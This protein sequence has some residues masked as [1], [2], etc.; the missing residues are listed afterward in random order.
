MDAWIGARNLCLQRCVFRWIENLVRHFDFDIIGWVSRVG[1]DLRDLRLCPIGS[2]SC[3]YS[4]IHF[5]FWLLNK[6]TRQYKWPRVFCPCP[7]GAK[8]V[9]SKMQNCEVNLNISSLDSNHFII[10]RNTTRLL[11]VCFRTHKTTLTLDYL[12]WY[13]WRYADGGTKQKWYPNPLWSSFSSDYIVIMM[14]ILGS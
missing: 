12:T 13:I 3:K 6:G 5:L 4:S 1:S 14:P 11:D 9:N 8:Y 2:Y 10:L 7:L